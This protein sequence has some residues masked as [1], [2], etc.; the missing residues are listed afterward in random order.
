MR[1][2]EQRHTELLAEFIEERKNLR[3]CG[4]VDR[5]CRFIGNQKP[6][7][8]GK[9]H[10]DH[11]SL[12]LAAGKLVRPGFQLTLRIP[13]PYLLQQLQCA[14]A[15]VVFFQFFVQD[16]GFT[17]LFFDRVQRVQ[18]QHGLLEDHA[19]ASAAHAPQCV[20]VGPKQLFPFKK[21]T[22]AGMTGPRIGQQSQDGNG[23]HGFPRSGF[24][25]QRNPLTR[26]NGER[27]VFNRINL[28][29]RS[30]KSHRQVTNLEQRA[31]SRG[32]VHHE[33]TALRGSKA[34]RTASPTNINRLSISPMTKNPV[35]PS[36]GACRFAL[37]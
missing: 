37:P 14:L 32:A 34:S 33:S 11:D 20:L 16:Q 2:Q 9:R 28:F 25:H 1:D 27:D 22:A 31:G 12:T 8:V 26:V 21:N 23:R 29:V 36:Q 13:D 18:R 6:G 4:D 35:N 5:R 15:R 3:L 10:G 24:A 7:L 19:D 17:D 30:R